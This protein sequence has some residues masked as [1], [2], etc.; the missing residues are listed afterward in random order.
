MLEPFPAVFGW[1]RRGYAPDMSASSWSKR[2]YIWFMAV[3]KS[4]WFFFFFFLDCNSFAIVFSS[5]CRCDV[6]LWI[7]FSISSAWLTARHELCVEDAELTS[8]LRLLSVAQGDV[9]SLFCFFPFKSVNQTHFHCTHAHRFS[10]CTAEAQECDLVA[11]S[12]ICASS[13]SQLA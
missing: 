1:R 12:Q 4:D 2:N 5:Y 7:M 3:H 10:S 6:S 8:C 13:T 9:V 11:S